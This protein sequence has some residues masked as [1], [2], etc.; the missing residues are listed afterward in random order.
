MGI[1]VENT[2]TH[3]A[4]IRKTHAQKHGHNA[5]AAVRTDRLIQ[6]VAAGDNVAQEVRPRA[7]RQRD[8]Q[9]LQQANRCSQG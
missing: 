5:R 9:V 8:I 1:A 6:G 7:L 2:R 4:G 3:S